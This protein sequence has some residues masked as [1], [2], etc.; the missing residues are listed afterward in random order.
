MQQDRKTE[1]LEVN[2]VAQPRSYG[3][4]RNKIKN[5]NQ[6][7]LHKPTYTA[8]PATRSKER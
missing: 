6:I 8:T 7:L 2:L 5:D 3:D 4:T 1:Q